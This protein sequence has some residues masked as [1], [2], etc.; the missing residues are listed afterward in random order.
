MKKKK[1][2]LIIFSVW[3]ISSFNLKA[4]KHENDYSKQ[5]ELC[6]GKIYN[7]SFFE[8]DSCINNSNDLPLCYKQFL[9]LNANWWKL[10]TSDE[11]QYI[12]EGFVCIL[13]G[14]DFL[15]KSKLDENEKNVSS[16]L[17]RVI[18]FEA[19]SI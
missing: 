17:F 15:E 5:I 16:N 19:A 8:A 1:I 12:T 7:F 11:P 6:F 3:L 14:L 2:I 18:S 13:K 4:F 10:V 9:L